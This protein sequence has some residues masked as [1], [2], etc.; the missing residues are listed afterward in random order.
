MELLKVPITYLGHLDSLTG[1]QIDHIAVRPTRYAT[2]VEC[3]DVLRQCARL[4]REDVLD[5]TQLLIQ[6]RRPGFG[7][8][9][10]F[11]VVHLLVPV[12]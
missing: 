5:L 9:F 12:D 7:M 2:L 10:R 3:H 6:G 11:V 1:P 4:V 8:C